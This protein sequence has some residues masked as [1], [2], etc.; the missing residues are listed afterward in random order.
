MTPALIGLTGS[1]R[2][3]DIH[4]LEDTLCLVWHDALQ[5]GYTGIE[6]MHG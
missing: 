5:V 2:W 6:L 4:N 1:R 3:T